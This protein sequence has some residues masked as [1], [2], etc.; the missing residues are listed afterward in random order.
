[1]TG[2][3]PS[4]V[5]RR[6]VADRLRA[7][8][9]LLAT[10]GWIQGTPEDDQGRHCMAGALYAVTDAEGVYLAASQAVRE[11]LND[12]DATSWGLVSWN[13]R[14]GRTAEQVIAV[15]RETAAE[16]DARAAALEAESHPD[17][18]LP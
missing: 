13:D 17:G 14:A 11:H 6:R 8:A 1:V 5:R 18:E 10:N 7:A 4:F 15:L 3:V 9:D 12:L 2:P 16:E